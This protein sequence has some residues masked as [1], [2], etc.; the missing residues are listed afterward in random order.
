MCCSCRTKLCPWDQCFPGKGNWQLSCLVNTQCL[1]PSCRISQYDGKQL[2]LGSQVMQ[3]RLGDSFQEMAFI[4]QQTAL[5][6]CSSWDSML[7]CIMHTFLILEKIKEC[8]F[9]LRSWRSSGN[10]MEPPSHKDTDVFLSTICV[11]FRS[12]HGMSAG[13][14]TRAPMGT[15]K[16]PS[17]TSE[18]WVTFGTENQSNVPALRAEEHIH[19]WR[20]QYL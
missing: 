11:L 4:Q 9:P 12:D 16:C 17:L 20:L 1:W 15:A 13:T 14:Q 5:C 19:S 6:C 3:R 10:H 7:T 8:K 2:I 18:H